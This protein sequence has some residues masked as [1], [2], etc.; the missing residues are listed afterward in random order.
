M[1]T[2]LD[3]LYQRKSTIRQLRSAVDIVTNPGEGQTESKELSWVNRFPEVE[4]NQNTDDFPEK[5]YGHTKRIEGGLSEVFRQI[6][7]AGWMPAFK[8]VV[9]N[10]VVK[11]PGMHN[12]EL[13]PEGAYETG[14]WV[15]GF[16]DPKGKFYTRGET[17]AILTGGPASY[18]DSSDIPQ[19]LEDPASLK[20]KEEVY[21]QWR[22]LEKD[23]AK[24]AGGFGQNF[25]SL[26]SPGTSAWSQTEVNDSYGN[27]NKYED[28]D[29]HLGDL[30]Q[31]ERGVEPPYS[32]MTNGPMSPATD[33]DKTYNIVRGAGIIKFYEGQ[34][35]IQAKE[36]RPNGTIVV[37]Q[38]P[39]HVAKQIV[40]SFPYTDIAPSKLHVSLAYI[41]EEPLSDEKLNKVREAIELVADA[42]TP[43][44][45]KIKDIATHDA[46]DSSELMATVACDG[47]DALRKSV[48]GALKASGFDIREGTLGPHISLTYSLTKLAS[49]MVYL[50][51]DGDDIGQQ[52]GRM[53]INDDVE[54]L[55]AIDEKIQAGGQVFA[56]FAESNDGE[57]IGIGGDEIRIMVPEDAIERLDDAISEYEEVTGFTISIGLGKKLSEADKAMIIAKFKGKDQVVTWEPEMEDILDEAKDKV[58]SKGEE[59]AVKHYLASVDPGIEWDSMEMVIM[60]GDKKIRIPFGKESK[61]AQKAKQPW[62]AI[63]MDKTLL[64][65]TQQDLPLGPVDERWIPFLQKWLDAGVRISVYTARLTVHPDEEQMVQQHLDAEGVPYTDIYIGPKPPADVYIDNA[66]VQ[67]QGDPSDAAKKV[68]TLLGFHM[69]HVQDEEKTANDLIDSQ[70]GGPNEEDLYTDVDETRLDRSIPRAPSMEGPIYGR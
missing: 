28:Q 20:R 45:C 36:V 35:V 17:N 68:D 13:L 57:V 26:N 15:D 55:K 33:D 50:T 53:S 24:E 21:N 61:R 67:F 44:H 34:L 4:D 23:E 25:N 6:I 10:L 42:H 9:T 52:V 54:G 1:Q 22:R 66:A 51:G 39:A 8:N 65:P 16:V 60:S 19:Q 59:K 18:F 3:R 40:E 58:L 5:D 49:K 64:Q 48:E 38:P 46:A 30:E 29:L 12:I 32:E 43:I 37:I 41:S 47:F 7:A 69:P 63:D 70:P 56:E 62:I 27:D 14:Q 31:T 2:K 11:S